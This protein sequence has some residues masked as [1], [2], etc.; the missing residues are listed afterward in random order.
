MTARKRNLSTLVAAAQSETSWL[1]RAE[2]LDNYPGMPEV[3]GRELLKAFRA[4]A[5]AL[6]AE[7]R[8][9]TARQA[10]KTKT[11]WR[12]LA[13]EEILSC[14]A[15]VLA[16]GAARPRLLPGEEALLGRGV[17]WCGTCD[18]MFYRGK[19]VAV[20]SAWDGG[21]AE[22]EFLAG[23]ASEVDY[24]TLAP[25]TLPVGGGITLREGTPKGLT[26]RED[27]TIT[28][29][30]L[31]SHEGYDGVF[32]F[33]PAVAPDRLV[34]GLEL[35]N[36]AIRTD[37]RMACGLPMLYACGDCTGAP[38]QVA[39]AV[40]EGNIAAISAAEDLKKAEEAAQ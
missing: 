37:R 22:A 26:S 12:V 7:I 21:R 38:Y 29:E 11:G 15:L 32:V 2:R 40:G 17:S 30:T 13:G 19:R 34:H 23:L 39:K 18:G 24:Y 14:R 4:Q 9:V 28:V 1:W 3:S 35:E 33:R 31:V 36:G 8:T 20:L 10:Q 16:V 25:H 6:G 5:E 27:G